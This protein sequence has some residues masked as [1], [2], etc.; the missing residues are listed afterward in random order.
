MLSNSCA[1]VGHST[2]HVIGAKY[3][4]VHE[5]EFNGAESTEEIG[6]IT[7]NSYINFRDEVLK[8]KPIKDYNLDYSN[9]DEVENAVVNERF[10]GLCPVPVTKEKVSEMLVEVLDIKSF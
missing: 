2:A 1:N 5:A 4:L 6:N 8:L 10:V 7:A 9:I 3:H